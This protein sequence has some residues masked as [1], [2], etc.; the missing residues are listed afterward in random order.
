MKELEDEEEEEEEKG[1]RKE[2]I[3]DGVVTP[4]DLS[5]VPW[6]HAQLYK[7]Y[8]RHADYYIHP[9]MQPEEKKIVHPTLKSQ[10]GKERT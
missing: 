7:M 8:G 1:S 3:D 4:A 5:S 9:K 2:K 10:K 6:H